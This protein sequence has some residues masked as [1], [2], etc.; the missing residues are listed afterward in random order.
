MKNLVE[1]PRVEKGFKVHLPLCIDKQS[2]S[3]ALIVENK[4]FSHLF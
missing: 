4:H 2:H 3:H 1:V